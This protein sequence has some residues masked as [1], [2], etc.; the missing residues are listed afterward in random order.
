MDDDLDAVRLSGKA[1]DAELHRAASVRASTCDVTTA[2][3]GVSPGYARLDIVTPGMLVGV[4]V[5]VGSGGV[6][7]M[8]VVSV[9]AAV[10]S[11]CTPSRCRPMR[12]SGRR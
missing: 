5:L 2:I 10:A 8:D 6:A 9:A 4:G 1:D 7:I 12:R 11:R 3:H